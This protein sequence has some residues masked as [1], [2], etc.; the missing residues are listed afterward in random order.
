MVVVKHF[1][2]WGLLAAHSVGGS[3]DSKVM[4]GKVDF[5]FM[6]MCCPAR[7]RHV[8]LVIDITDR[9]EARMGIYLSNGETLAVLLVCTMHS[10]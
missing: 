2:V 7:Q 10:S 1:Q 6:L 8:V 9:L 3:L 4:G 5:L